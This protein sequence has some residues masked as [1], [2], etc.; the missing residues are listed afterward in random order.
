MTIF[1]HHQR[2]LVIFAPDDD[3]QALRIGLHCVV[4]GL[5]EELVVEHPL[6]EDKP[7][8]LL[9][10]E[11]HLVRDGWRDWWTSRDLAL[12]VRVHV[13]EPDDLV[14]SDPSSERLSTALS[15]HDCHAEIREAVH[16][17]G[18]EAEQGDLQTGVSVGVHSIVGLHHD[19][20]L[21]AAVFHKAFTV[22]RGDVESKSCGVEA[23]G[24]AL[25]LI[26]E[27][28]LPQV[29]QEHDETLAHALC[30]V[31]L[32]KLGEGEL[33]EEGEALDETHASR[34]DCVQ[35]LEDE[36]PDLAGAFH[37]EELKA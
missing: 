17:L 29:L 12:A 9:L 20:P 11:L 36:E 4:V 28:E 13:E 16:D 22:S 8:P 27:A 1:G 2:P 7:V 24:V 15:C 30:A 19:V 14:G 21:R 34:G 23:A 32:A 26:D 35:I 18:E 25:P 5:G 3:S 37:E 31:V 33:E 10:P 6:R